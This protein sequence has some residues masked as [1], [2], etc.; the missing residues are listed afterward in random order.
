MLL[1]YFGAKK[2]EQ[3][4]ELK[5]VFISS[6]RNALSSPS[7]QLEHHL[8][9][10]GALIK[11]SYYL[12]GL[13]Y[14][15]FS[16]FT[17]IA[18]LKSFFESMSLYFHKE[19]VYK[20]RESFL[21][22]AIEEHLQQMKNSPTDLE[23]HVSLAHNFVSLSKIYMEAQEVSFPRSFKKIAK[24]A[25]SKFEITSKRAIEEFIIL[26]EFAPNDPWI[27]AQLAL[28]YNHLK[29]YEEEAREYELMLELSPNDKEVM[30]RLGK[31]YFELGKNSLGLQ[32]YETLKKEAFEKA[33]DLL[34]FYSSSNFFNQIE[35]N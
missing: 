8:S 23:L 12:H 13:E 18:F 28:C 10:A 14:S 31:I 34:E 30:F 26:K 17:K 9:I 5:N 1:F 19:D 29:M 24:E 27:H 33:E 2:P 20:V 22:S 4:L 6:C 3:F 32:I 15:F 25:K 16:S 11:L 7:G 21:L 35:L